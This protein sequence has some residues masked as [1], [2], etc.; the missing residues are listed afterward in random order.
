MQDCNST[1]LVLKCGH[2]T[3]FGQC[4]VRSSFATSLWKHLRACA[5]PYIFFFPDELTEEAKR[6]ISWTYRMVNLPAAL[7]HYV[8]T[9]R[10]V[11]H[12]TDQITA[13][14]LYV[15]NKSLLG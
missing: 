3:C 7:G 14:F 6:S 1:P 12:V 15:R 13:E 5:Q 2:V 9:Q 10:T 4:S 8:T 11:V